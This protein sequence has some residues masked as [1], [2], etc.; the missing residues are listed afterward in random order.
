MRL[1][2]RRH[3][4]ECSR[5]YNLVTRP[6]RVAGLC[7]ADGAPLTAREDD[8][9]KAIRDRERAYH[10][11]T[12]P[13]LRWYNAARARRVDGTM[14][15]HQVARAASRAALEACRA[16]EACACPA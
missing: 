7:D 2:A 3:C 5:V 6:P 9:D 14:S 1:C 16:L 8:R 15:P 12:G 10:R 11:Q 13:V 4:T